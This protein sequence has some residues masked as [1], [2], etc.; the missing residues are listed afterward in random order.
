MLRQVGISKD[1]A[2]GRLRAFEVLG[3]K[4]AVANV[5]G[6]FY[7]FED[8]CPHRGCSLAKGTLAG[9][10]ATCGCHGSQFDVTSGAVLRGPATR[11]VRSWT[12]QV[13]GEDLLVDPG[14]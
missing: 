5:E 4:V 3:G 10:T 9:T 2:A 13:T 6:R 14:T 8:T 1:I 11:P 7:A 12:V